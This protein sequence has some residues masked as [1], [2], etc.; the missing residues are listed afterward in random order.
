MG[1]KLQT[2]ADI[3][4]SYN[5]SFPLG[6][7]AINT[8]KYDLRV[9]GNI[10]SFEELLNIPISLSEGGSVPLGHFA[11]LHRKWNGSAINHMNIGVQTGLPFIQLN[12]NKEP[13]KSVFETAKITRAELDAYVSKLGPTWK[14]VYGL[15]LAEIIT[16]D[17]RNLANNAWQTIL[18]VAICI[19]FF[20]GLKESLIASITIP[21]AF[22]V[23]IM[24]L[25]RMDMSLNFMTNF[26]LV[27]SFGIAIDLTL[28]IIEETAK[29]VKL[30]YDPG[31]AV[32]LAVNELKL[33]VISS[34]AVTLV[35]FIPMMMLPG[36]IGKFLSYIP[37]TVFSSL[38]ATL[39]LAL[40]TNSSLFVKLARPRLTYVRQPAIEEHLS[41]EERILL[42]EERSNKLERPASSE[43]L[44]EKIIE[45]AE[46]WY[47][48]SLTRWL[49]TS[50]RRRI[51]IWVPILLTIIS[52]F[53][54]TPRLI[55]G[56]LFPTE[57]SP[58]IFININAP[59]GTKQ[60]ELLRMVTVDNVPLEERFAPF[61]EIK[62]VTFHIADEKVTLYV[63]LTTVN[64]RKQKHERTSQELEV[65][66]SKA[67]SPLLSQG[68]TVGI[69]ADQN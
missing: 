60:T 20:V 49:A 34:T 61:P 66:F 44:R 4:R 28:V 40:T 7:F 65:A 21:L 62:L 15:D 6:S 46:N 24:T 69:K 22:L 57:D 55:G 63:E 8:K 58:F 56:G 19:V 45:W 42:T 64:E 37:L 9:E 32:L 36:I 47:E 30:G 17:Y 5:Q 59:P 3:I 12:F 48:Q 26:S 53:V 2:I 68:V 50:F 16:E 27:L 35:V 67:L 41:E 14:I 23:S 33:S 39:F 10:E 1:L 54:L 52:F 25:N 43:T 13:G 38:L 29:K 31:T 11:T 51:L 18:L